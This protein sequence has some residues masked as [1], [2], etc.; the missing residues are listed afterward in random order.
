MYTAE[1][2]LNL[3]MKPRINDITIKVLADYYAF[4]LNPFIYKYTLKSNPLK[5]FELWFDKEN[6]CHLLGLETI[7]KNSV[8]FKKLHNYKGIDGW[9]NI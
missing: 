1:E 6:F 9:Q 4:F 7:A 2:L 3:Q 8:P 5:S